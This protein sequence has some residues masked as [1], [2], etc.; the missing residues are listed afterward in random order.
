M[1]YLVF[2][3]GSGTNFEEMYRC[4]QDGI[5]F[6]EMVA[7]VVNKNA[8]KVLDRTKKYNIK[9]IQLVWNKKECSREIYE[10]KLYDSVKDLDCDMGVCLG[11]NHIFTKTFINLFNKPLYNLH[12]S[13]PNDIIGWNAIDKAY[14]E[15]R[16]NKRIKTGLMFHQIT[17]KVDK[18]AVVYS[19]E[20]PFLEN[21]SY[22]SYYGRMRKLE[23]TVVLNGLLKV[24][25]E[26]KEK[27]D[28]VY[29]G[30]VRDVYDIGYNLLA[31]KAT[32]R[33]SAYDKQIT[34]IGN[35]G[36]V[37]NKL[38][39]WWFNKTKHIV[40]NHLIWSNGDTSVVKKT[41]PIKLEMVVRSYMTGS[42]KTSLWTH[43]KNGARTYCGNRLHDNYTKNCKL[44]SP[45]VTPTTKG[46][47]ED[48]PISYTEIIEK[49]IMNRTELDFIYE[50]S[51]E[52]FNYG[53]YLAEK[54]GFI[55]VDTKYEFG[56]D[57]DGNIILIDEIHTCD[58]SRYWDLATYQE[59]FSNGQEPIS[60]DKDVIRKY[61]KT[62]CDPYHDIIP[63]IPQE[64]KE[65]TENTYV[66][67]YEQLTDMTLCQNDLTFE[68][69]IKYYFNFEH[70]N[71]VVILAGSKSDEEWVK[72]IVNN[73]KNVYCEVHYC[74]AHKQ[75]R[76]LIILLDHY[77]KL[78]GNIVYITV[79][80]MCNALSGVVAANTNNLVLAVPPFKDKMDMMVNVHSSLQCP[81]N[82]PVCTILNPKNVGLVVNRYFNKG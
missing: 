81:S 77:N 64:L 25:S 74:S 34:E 78:N 37:L 14:D 62:V 79:A 12:P 65:K 15:F 48:V 28:L 2:A 23:K 63:S 68:D 49:G 52:L 69:K 82:V 38:S 33:L 55:L 3:S 57:T 70:K 44:E 51:L 29:R 61:L 58:S 43:Y 53:V 71:R 21:D 36:V 40:D 10:V 47:F 45:I 72:K 4:I 19:Q 35:K 41:K 32:D 42:T 5:L 80:G 60:L 30:K 1:K 54:K 11:W 76:E 16:Q 20:V 59:R 31:L 27:Q 46:E 39:E 66:N 9:T 8:V 7:C 22:E 56:Y 75:P 24:L 6:G 13:L 18:G 26:Q 17:E 73:L 50:K 67:F